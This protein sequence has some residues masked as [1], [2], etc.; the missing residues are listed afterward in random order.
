MPPGRSLRQPCYEEAQ[1][2][3][4]KS[5]DGMTGKMP[6]QQPDVPHTADPTRH[7]RQSY[8]AEPLQVPDSQNP[9]E[10]LLKSLC[11]EMLSFRVNYYTAL[12]SWRR[13]DLLEK[14]LML[15]KIEDRRRRG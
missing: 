15:G 10:M 9:R 11:F 12:E 5:R 13:T 3:L 7:S 2:S 8:S 4:V 14:T 1:A 6:G